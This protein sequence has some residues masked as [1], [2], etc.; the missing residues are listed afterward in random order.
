MTTEKCTVSR[1]CHS[2]SAT[3]R[4]H[5][6]RS[7]TTNCI[8]TCPRSAHITLWPSNICPWHATN[9]SDSATHR[10]TNLLE[11]G[12]LL[13]QSESMFKAFVWIVTVV[14]IVATL[15]THSS[16]ALAADGKKPNILFI[17]G[18]DM[19]YAD[20]GFHGCQD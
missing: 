3:I 12:V 20:L 17:V 2:R 11:T 1:S 6:T 10:L 5:P 9:S 8:R 13:E 4:S 15:S 19:G 7:F 18:D 16:L 14:C